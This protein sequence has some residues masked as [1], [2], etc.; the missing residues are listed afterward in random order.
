MKGLIIKN[1]SNQYTVLAD[2]NKYVCKCRGK[3]R[4]I[5]LTPLVGDQ[6]EFS[7]DD[8]YILNIDKRKNELKRPQISNVSQALIITSVKRPKLSLFLLD[9]MI[10][11]ISI[12]NITPVIVF[13]KVDLLNDEE[14][15]CFYTIYNYYKSIGY[16]VLTNQELDKLMDI[17][18]D[19]IVVLTG[20]TGSGKSTLLN[21]L[22][23][24]L[25]LKTDD[26]SDALNRG[27]HTTR[28][29]ELYKIGPSFIADT[30]GFSSFD[31]DSINRLDIRLYF[32]E[33]DN[34]ACKYRNCIHKDEESCKVKE[35]VLN[36]K[37]LKS[38]YENY[39]KMVK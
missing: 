37:I 5:N 11:N 12:N 20:Q 19:K 29:V 27:K 34:N 24:K 14:L 35:D 18:K 22:D 15:K 31:I 6:V 17:I 10:V 28:H 38:R 39:L 2:N 23:P 32:K 25:K 7:K 13:T 9:K 26:I 36:K 1:I 30:P 21:K 8:H 4:N 16:D 33:F 3:F